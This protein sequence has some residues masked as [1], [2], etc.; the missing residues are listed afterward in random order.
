MEID[1][2]WYQGVCNIGFKP[3]F[4]QPALRPSVEVHLFQFNQDIYGK[5]VMV[6]WHLYLRR[7]QKFSGIEELVSQIEKDKQ[8]AI[9]YFVRNRQFFC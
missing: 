7:E 6:E 2:V 4:N 3:T 9:D 1:G 5:N 8:N